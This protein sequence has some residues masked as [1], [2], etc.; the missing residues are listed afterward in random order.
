MDKEKLLSLGAKTEQKIEYL[1]SIKYDGL[2]GKITDLESVLKEFREGGNTLLSEGDILQIGIVG[3]VKAGKSS[4]LNSLFFDGE[5]ILPKASTPM[6]AGLTIIEYAEK[7]SFEVE[8]FSD[9]DWQIF[10]D[11][12]EEYRLIAKEVEEH[13]PQA[14]DHI[15]KKEIESRASDRIR[16]AHEMVSSCTSTAKN[17]IGKENDSKEFSGLKDLQDILETYVGADGEFTSVVKSL[18]IR[19]SNGRLKGMRIVDT[20]GVNDPVVS[21]ENRTRTFLHACHG[22]FLLSASSDF[23][24]SGDISFLNTRIGGSG[25]GT[26]VLL[27]SKFD[28]VLQDIG[29]ER[30]MKQEG[31]G[32]LLDTVEWQTKKFNNRLRELSG[33]IDEKLQGRLKLDTTAGIGFSIAHKPSS[34]WDETEKQVVQQMKRFY[35]DYFA[36][37]SDIKENFDGLANLDTIKKEY[38]DGVFMANKDTIIKEKIQDFFQKNKGEVVSTLNDIEKSFNLRFEQLNEATIAEIEKQKEIQKALFENVKKKFVT[39]FN[40]WGIRL[41]SEIK[42]IAND[43][44]F[45]EIRYIPTENIERYVT[46]KG[47]LWGHNNVLV[48]Y[49][50]V[51]TQRLSKEI[52][53]AVDQYSRAW[54]NRWKKIFEDAKKEMA[55]KLN[56]V[57][58]D[59]EKQIRST[60]FNDAYYRVLIDETLD[61]MQINKELSIRDII[62]NYRRQGSDIAK[63][64]VNIAGTRNKKE[65]ELYGYLEDC[66]EAHTSKLEKEFRILADS[67]KEDVK[68]EVDKNLKGALSLVEEMKKSFADNLQKE[69]DEYLASLEKDLKEKTVTLDKVKSIITC[70]GEL[71]TLYTV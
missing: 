70:I 5:N 43:I 12:D 23:L 45:E 59:V 48:E 39:I 28:S 67:I 56:D 36:T 71:K 19:L 9:E 8:Y 29:A 31:R 68:N 37:D 35:P 64:Q 33:D 4:F 52:Q 21:R 44:L 34:R 24:G 41:Q 49:K 20:P 17:K 40:S 1:K 10:V 62:D 61:K 47:W 55:S 11:Q 38:L 60:S 57:I 18:H 53:E 58:C 65:G 26:V 69:G 54:N 66:V 27:A 7:N 14:P 3:Q 2:K 32:D 42:S 50:Q 15:K 22:V 51:N 30:E 16:A 6:T 63:K 46:C 13:D 25:I